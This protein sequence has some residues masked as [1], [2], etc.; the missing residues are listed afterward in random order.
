MDHVKGITLI[1]ILVAMAIL[2]VI[3]AIA[4]PAYRGYITTGHKAECQNEVA[5]IKLAEAEFF[6]EN[7]NYFVGGDTATL[8]GASQG[9]YTPSTA[10]TAAT[11]ECTYVV[12]A[13]TT[14]YTITANFGAG[15]HLTGETN[16]IVTFT[17]P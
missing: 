14:N 16:P 17:G 3:A 15:G 12:T 1:E 11:S 4:M 6:L 10:A 13:T 9:T 5:A 8:A 7:N 2:S